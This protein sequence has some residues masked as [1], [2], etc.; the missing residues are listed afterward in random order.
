MVF[1]RGG[2]VGRTRWPGGSL[3]RAG[4]QGVNQTS[5]RRQ[6]GECPGNEGSGSGEIRNGSNDNGNSS[7]CCN[8]SASY[9]SATCNDSG[10]TG[11]AGS[12]SSAASNTATGNNKSGAKTTSKRYYTIT[13]RQK[14]LSIYY[15]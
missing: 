9:G 7:K 3:C 4:L 6:S 2:R 14:Y 5:D 1:K 15:A 8:S 10:Q 13:F 11:T 12:N